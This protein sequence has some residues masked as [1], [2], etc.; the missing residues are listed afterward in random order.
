MWV[1]SV[2]VL[3]A[4]VIEGA[5]LSAWKVFNVGFAVAVI[6]LGSLALAG[7]MILHFVLPS[8]EEKV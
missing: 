2:S 7:L 6:V 5:W 3:T 8:F 1:P 4:A